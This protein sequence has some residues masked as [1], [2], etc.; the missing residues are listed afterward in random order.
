MPYVSGRVLSWYEDIMPVAETRLT[1][2]ATEQQGTLAFSVFPSGHMT[3]IQR[4]INVAT[5][6]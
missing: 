5:T 6:S 1:V 3:L 2:M 4:R